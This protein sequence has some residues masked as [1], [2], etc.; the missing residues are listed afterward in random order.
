MKPRFISSFVL[1]ICFCYSS[2]SK[3]ELITFDFSGAFSRVQPIDTE[4]SPDVRL[5]DIYFG[6]FTYD[7]AA[8]LF[9]TSD[10]NTRARYNTGFMTIST[11]VNGYDA[12]SSPQLQ[13]FNNWMFSDG[14]TVIDDFFLSVDQPDNTGPGFYLLQ[15]ILR[16]YTYSTLDN[17]SI[18]TVD[19][20]F[21]L[22]SGG[23]FYL[24]RF[25]SSEQEQ[26]FADGSFSIT[27]PIIVNVPAPPTIYL[28][29]LGLVFIA[30]RLI[31]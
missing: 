30:R 29:V 2:M 11:G 1:F 25:A 7:N 27:S 26:W 3:A 6:Q 19:E 13:I 15:L 18:P 28:F 31:K 17:L 14:S 4:S 20:I 23:H 21:A 22:S 16:D 24:R 8:P 5:G 10:A 12:S 9:G